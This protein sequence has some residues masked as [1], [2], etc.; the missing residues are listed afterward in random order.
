MSEYLR[1]G[2][3][4]FRMKAFAD[5][6]YA[7]SSELHNLTLNLDHTV[8]H[9]KLRCRRVGGAIAAPLGSSWGGYQVYIY[10]YI[11]Y[12]YIYIYLSL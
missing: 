5:I 8:I 3:Q 9:Q 6:P 4:K 1:E 7:V 12:V 2:S 11:C 10:I